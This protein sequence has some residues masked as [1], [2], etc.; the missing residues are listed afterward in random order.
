MFLA[1]CWIDGM[2]IDPTSKIIWMKANKNLKI[3]FLLAQYSNN[4]GV[5]TIQSWIS[6]SQSQSQLLQEFYE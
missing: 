5:N 3:F 4:K 1:L 2:I 6:I